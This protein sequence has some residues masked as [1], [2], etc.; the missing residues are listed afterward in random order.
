M[1]D[2]YTSGNSRII[3]TQKE[4]GMSCKRTELTHSSKS[5]MIKTTKRL[6]ENKSAKDTIWFEVSQH[7]RFNFKSTY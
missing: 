4:G 2:L 7:L 6:R 3:I 5:N 1:I